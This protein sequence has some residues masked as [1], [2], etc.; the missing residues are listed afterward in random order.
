MKIRSLTNEQREK[1]KSIASSYLTFYQ[2][3]NPNLS[4]YSHNMYSRALA[5][6]AVENNLL[7]FQP[8]DLAVELT[9]DILTTSDFVKIVG[10]DSG[11]NQNIRLSAFRNLVSPFKNDLKSEISSVSYE[12]L[13]KLLSRKGTHIR[14]TILESKTQNLKTE[15]ELMKSRSWK[16]LQ[17]VVKDMNVKYN[18]IVNKFL[19][20]NEIPD[21]VTLRNILIGNLYMFNIHEHE[22]IPVHVILR[23]EYRTAHLWINDKEPPLDKTNYFWIN[24][25]N[26]KHY[27]I[28]QKGRT[29]QGNNLP[30]KMRKQ[31]PL[32]QQ[33][34]NMILFIK[35]TFNESPDKPFFKNQIREATPHSTE[36]IRIVG[37]I[38]ESISTSITCSTIRNIY[39]NEIDWSKVN[40]NQID[41]IRSQL[42][43]S[44][45]IKIDEIQFGNPEQVAF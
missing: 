31:F 21:Y 41:Y 3:M 30:H 27:I 6:I 13:L 4:N 29:V 15:T 9:K 42:D 34:V 8:K 35:Q 2:D 44:D 10:H 12:T 25:S 5:Y 22:S 26:N 11:S 17:K 7:D 40:Q 28:I 38:F 1:F 24:F 32:S 23:N 45:R 16:D 33:I 20:T 37:K 19:K 36:W 18:Q 14:K 39:L 43:W